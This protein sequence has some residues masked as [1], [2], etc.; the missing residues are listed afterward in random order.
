MYVDDFI[1]SLSSDANGDF[2]GTLSKCVDKSLTNVFD[3]QVKKLS[4]IQIEL[5]QQKEISTQDYNMISE[6]IENLKDYIINSKSYK[7]NI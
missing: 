3:I 2:D 4:D 1:W 6:M 7:R 5:I